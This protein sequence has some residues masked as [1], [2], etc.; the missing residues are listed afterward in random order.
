MVPVGDTLVQTTTLLKISYYS[1]EITL[2]INKH[3]LMC[4]ME[5]HIQSVLL[6]GFNRVW[7]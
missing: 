7:L 1:I 6:L 2:D 4:G 3:T 5:L